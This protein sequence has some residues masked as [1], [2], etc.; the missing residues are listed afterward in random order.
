MNSSS[1]R[2][3]AVTELAALVLPFLEVRDLSSV[4]RT[5]R[6]YYNLGLPLLY[7]TVDTEKHGKLLTHS[8]C[9]R[10]FRR[11]LHHV[12]EITCNR[13]FLDLYHRHTSSTPSS[14]RL[15]NLTHLTFIPKVHHNHLFRSNPRPNKQL[16]HLSH[17]MRLSPNLRSIVVDILPISNEAT[18]V[19]L[20][21]VLKG[22]QKLE[23]MEMTL[24]IPESQTKP[25]A[26]SLFLSA[27]SCLKVFRIMLMNQ[28][29]LGFPF[30][31]ELSDPNPWVQDYIRSL[32]QTPRT[33]LREWDIDGNCHFVFEDTLQMLDKCPE[34]VTCCMP[35][36]VTNLS[37]NYVA[38]LFL[39]YNPKL[40]SLAQWSK[41][42]ATQSSVIVSVAKIMPPRTLETFRYRGRP[43]TIL[44]VGASLRPHFPS[45]INL[46]LDCG[47][48]LDSD[49]IRTILVGCPNLE[50]CEFK[51]HSY[52][53]LQDAVAKPWASTKIRKLELGVDFGDLDKA[54]LDQDWSKLSTKKKALLRQ[55]E[56]FYRQIGSLTNLTHLDIKVRAELKDNLSDPSDPFAGIG[57]CNYT[58]M[59]CPRMI[60]LGDGMMSRNRGWLNCLAGLKKLE[61]LCG[62]F[63]QDARRAE[64][65]LGQ[66][67]VEWIATNWPKLTQAAFYYV[68]GEYPKK[69]NERALPPHMK[70]LTKR[71][72]NLDITTPLATLIGR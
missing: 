33:A 65:L 69:A 56:A 37:D 63:A 13:V 34:I 15:N 64:S 32:P 47:V 8:E 45:L 39:V 9:V 4:M 35:P 42:P 22:C 38:P 36:Y 68:D 3:F 7:R 70:W 23:T 66:A 29:D 30:R 43:Y 48:M 40:K 71:R 14:S 18:L 6:V 54:T 31:P 25:V 5:C 16:V 46:A 20:N 51:F 44:P 62:S 28:N 24:W 59:Y 21:K 41:V 17:A 50:E 67:E 55:L 57:L 49:T 52:I 12:R 27:P 19:D 2:F 10:S 72:P 58:D 26:T 60:K 11:N 61:V 53:F 1:A